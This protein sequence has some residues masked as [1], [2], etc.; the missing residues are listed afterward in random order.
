MILVKYTEQ[1]FNMW[2]MFNN[3][4][5]LFLYNTYMTYTPE[6]IPELSLMVNCMGQCQWLYTSLNYQRTLRKDILYEI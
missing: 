3:L 6:M 4:S 2:Q 1:H 5:L